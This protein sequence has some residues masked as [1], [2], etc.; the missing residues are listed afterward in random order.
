MYC[1]RLCFLMGVAAGALL[2]FSPGLRGDGPARAEPAQIRVLVPADAQ[3]EIGGGKTD[4]TGTV[5]RFVTPPLQPGETFTYTL[6]ASW[7]EQGKLVVR[8]RTVKVQAG[9]ETTVDLAEPDPPTTAPG[10]LDWGERRARSGEWVRA[11]EAY[12]NALQLDPRLTVAYLGRADAL[13]HTRG[14]QVPADQILEDCNAALRLAPDNPRAHALR[15]WAYCHKDKQYEQ[16]LAD[17]NAALQRDPENALAF[18]HRG[19]T[20][21]HLQDYERALTDTTT[22]IRLAPRLALAYR[23]RGTVYRDR[24]QYDKAVADLTEAVRLDPTSDAAF[25]TRAYAYISMGQYD[26]GIAD[27]T[28]ALRLNPKNVAAYN[29]R[30]WAYNSKGQYRQGILECNEAL[31][32]NPEYAMAYNNRGWAYIELGQL[33]QGIADCT[34][35]L[36][37]NPKNVHAYRNRGKAYSKRGDRARADADYAAARA[38][39]SQAETSAPVTATAEKF[40]PSEGGFSIRMPGSPRRKSTTAQT[41]VGE[42]AVT[43]YLLDRG[44]IAYSIDYADLPGGAVPQVNFTINRIVAVYRGNQLTTKDVKLGGHAGKEAVF[45][46]P[47]KDISIRLRAYAVGGRLYRVMVAG[48][49][50]FVRSTKADGFFDSFEVNR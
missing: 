42:V 50:Q 26:Q 1:T 9:K 34:R 28:A 23:D 15:A 41:E 27:A 12:T 33:D 37:L 35:A 47:E 40:T 48:P 31:R 18:A 19:H 43:M 17:C 7:R 38:L 32:L 6:R 29:N 14:E 25:N 4:Q 10:W 8:E 44:E 45:D 3:V 49:R 11:V 22:A 21:W 39:T 36:Q 13:S 30:G 2:G 5:R 20:Y 46:V 24:R 16:A